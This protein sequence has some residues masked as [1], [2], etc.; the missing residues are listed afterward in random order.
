MVTGFTEQ[1]RIAGGGELRLERFGVERESV[2]SAVEPGEE[3]GAAGRADG[4]RDER[5]GEADAVLGELI[6]VG[7]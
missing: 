7:C 5:V 2:V 4:C 3:A 6:K 1:S